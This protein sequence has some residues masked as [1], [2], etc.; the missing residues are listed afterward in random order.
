MGKKKTIFAVALC[1]VVILAI[2]CKS[3]V[4]N[5][6]GSVAYEKIYG[7]NTKEDTS[8]KEIAKEQNKE[9]GQKITTS[10]VKT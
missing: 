5:I 7:N 1:F 10:S 2:G 6:T 8:S 3:G 4:G 9:A